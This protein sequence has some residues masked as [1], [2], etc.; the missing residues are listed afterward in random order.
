ML[1]Y[2]GGKIDEQ[3]YFAGHIVLGIGMKEFLPG[4][5]FLFVKSRGERR[6]V[7]RCL[8]SLGLH[9]VAAETLELSQAQH[10]HENRRTCTSKSR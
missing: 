7:R 1:N 10:Q 8:D 3:A 5:L 9:K 4:N 2:I 6:R